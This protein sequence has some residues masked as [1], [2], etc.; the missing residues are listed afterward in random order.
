MPSEQDD[1]VVPEVLVQKGV[2]VPL[3]Q[4]TGRALDD[5]PSEKMR[6]RMQFEIVRRPESGAALL[7]CVC[8]SLYL[9]LS[10]R[11]SSSKSKTRFHPS[12]VREKERERASELAGPF[13]ALARGPFSRA[14]VARDE[15]EDLPETS[16]AG[17]ARERADAI[18]AARVRRGG[19]GAAAREDGEAR[20]CADSSGAACS[21][22]RDERPR[23]PRARDQTPGLKK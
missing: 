3:N 15:E 19:R 21:A 4:R 14:L 7:L 17:A 13:L 8:V 22:A 2:R 9:S 23:P 10:P 11:R 20:G 18:R 1:E 5:D 12:P 16:G 6:Q